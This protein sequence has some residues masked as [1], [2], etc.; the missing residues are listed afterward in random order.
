MRVGVRDLKARLSKYLRQVRQ[1]QTVIITDH[2]RPV[3]RLS[4]VDQPLDERLKSLQDAGLVAWNGQ[5]LKY[6]IPVA[7]NRGERQVSEILVEMRE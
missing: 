2:G 3:G 5:K 4:P 7:I 6:V 1:G